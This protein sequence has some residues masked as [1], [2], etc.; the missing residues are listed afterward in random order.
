MSILERMNLTKKEVEEVEKKL[1]YERQIERYCM[2]RQWCRG[3]ILDFGCGCG[4]GTYLVSKNPDVKFIR[5]Y[6]ISLEAINWAE[7]NFCGDKIEYKSVLEIEDFDMLLA[8][9][10]IEHIEDKSVI[11]NIANQINTKEI[12]VSYPSKKTTHY[13]KFHYHDYDTQ[14]IINLFK[15]FKLLKEINF[16]EESN[17]L[18]FIKDFI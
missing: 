12:I 4:Y 3:K 8:M 1:S 16:H 7:K 15:G 14:E 2:I 6:D 18:I 10:V 11:P 9:D 17:V 5:G 13:N